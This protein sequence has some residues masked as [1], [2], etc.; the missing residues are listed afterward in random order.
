M[1]DVT[2]VGILVADAIAR[3]VDGLPE[4]GKLEL[5]DKIELFSGGCAAN[6]A[7]DM[8]KLGLNIAIVGKIGNDGFGKFMFN[9]LKDEKVNVEGL[10]VDGNTGTSSSLV[11]VDSN[12]ERSFLHYLGA[13]AEFVID[14]INFDIIENSKI[15]FV[16]GTMLMPKFDGIQCA[17]FLKNVKEMGKYTVL[18]TAWDSKGRWMNLLNPCMKYIDLFIPSLEEAIMFSGKEEPEEISDVF[19]SMGV[20]TV[21]IKLGKK[22]C[23]IKDQNGEKH[24]IPTYTKVKAVDTTGAGDSF[25]AG[26]LTGLTKGWNL[27]ECGKFANAVGT[28]CVMAAGASTG[29]KNFEETF[30]FI[31]NNEIGG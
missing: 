23:F 10:K 24:L 7:I 22:G 11:T 17:D 27:Y 30:M 19:L 4:S 3:T 13:N 29:I 28:H 18:D 25:V 14:D 8:S 16:A 31:K 15:I 20:K 9:S 5:I 2:C 6:S 12:G 26:F 21:V 1:F